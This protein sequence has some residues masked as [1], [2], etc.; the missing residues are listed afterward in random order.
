MSVAKLVTGIISIIIFVISGLQSCA[1]TIANAVGKLNKISG[2][3]GV[4]V[5]FL[6]LTMGIVSIATR[7]K[8]VKGGC[9]AIISLS[10]TALFIGY[11]FMGD[12]QD[13]IIWLVWSAVMGILSFV[14]LI[15]I[16]K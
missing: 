12:F 13:L 3:V 6:I 8:N 15:I 11:M 7:S 10:V 2:V 9:I 5:S 1:L 14:H 16:E 4:F